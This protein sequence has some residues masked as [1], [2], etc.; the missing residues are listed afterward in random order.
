M[1]MSVLSSKRLVSLT[2]EQSEAPAVYD[3]STP[4]SGTCT[5]EKD[6]ATHQPYSGCAMRAE[7][8]RPDLPRRVTAMW[9]EDQYLI[10]KTTKLR[11]RFPPLFSQHNPQTYRGAMIVFLQ[12]FMAENWSGNS[13]C[14]RISNVAQVAFTVR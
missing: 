8:F 2:F 14:H 3:G 6:D 13:G 7:Y 1:S 5:V 9:Y 11:F 12:L 10:A 4:W